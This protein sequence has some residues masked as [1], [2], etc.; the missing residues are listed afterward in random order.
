MSNDAPVGVTIVGSANMDIVFAVDRI[1]RPGETL[2]ADSA[3]RF[4]GGKGLN[5]AVA[6]ARASAPTRF[7]GALGRDENGAA[8][9]ATMDDAG[10]DSTL[11]RRVSDPTGQAF[12]VVDGSGENTI[13]VASGAN[14]TVTDLGEGDREALALTAVLLMQLELPLAAVRSAASV[15]HTAGGIVI[16]N[17]APAQPVP[18]EL[19]DSLDYLVVNEHEACLV[20]ESADLE[21]A[22]ARLASLVS[23]LVV[24][25]G[26]AGSVLFD[27]GVE[28]ARIAAPKVTTVDTT[29]A[30]D[31][32]C[33]AFAAAIAEGMD[34][35]DAA[36]FA[37]AAAALSVQA[38]G[39]VPSVPQRA[40]IDAV[41]TDR[42]EA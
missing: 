35:A 26:S 24:T 6:A 23:R 14:A 41:L 19:L 8:L 42:T 39:A 13:I 17:A 12:I 32:F 34:F 4:P 27:D 30:G 16:L 36:R 22:S 10:I 18:R 15:T 20:G 29:G 37:T 33:G 3:Q 11:V 31:T 9:A 1:P 21:V 25:L 5:Q 40:A 2:L 7:I 38:V 28:V